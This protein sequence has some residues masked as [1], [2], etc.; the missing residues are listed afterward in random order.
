MISP[1]KN[2]TVRGGR[3]REDTIHQSRR[4]KIIFCKV[5]KKQPIGVLGE[6]SWEK[7]QPFLFS[8]LGIRLEIASCFLESKKIEIRSFKKSKEST[9]K[10]NGILHKSFHQG[11]GKEERSWTVLEGREEILSDLEVNLGKSKPNF[12]IKKLLSFKKKIKTY[13]REM[14]TK[15]YYEDDLW[16]L[17][18]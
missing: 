2:R 9:P 14:I 15:N 10:V 17:E 8:D 13:Y 1:C 4:D 3:T 12:I 18:E 16:H 11:A 7:L 5:F 6:R